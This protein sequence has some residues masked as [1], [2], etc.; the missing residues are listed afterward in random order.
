MENGVPDEVVAEIWKL[1]LEGRNAVDETD[2]HDIQES[3]FT[4]SPTKVDKRNDASDS[5]EE[6]S[7]C[8]AQRRTRRN[9]NK[10][11]TTTREKA[12]GRTLSRE[13]VRS[14]LAAMRRTR[15]R[16]RTKQQDI[17]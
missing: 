13:N 6:A 5:N 17:H 1:R 15:R 9:M 7:T 4:E 8:L 10:R 14:I 16:G 3:D 12:L 2:S 11:G